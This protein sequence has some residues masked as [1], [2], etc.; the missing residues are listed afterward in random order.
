MCHKRE[1]MPSREVVQK[2]IADYQDL[3]IR[4]SDATEDALR[5]RHAYKV[6]NKMSDKI[7]K[8]FNRFR[9]DDTLVEEVL[10]RSL[11][12]EDIR[13]R[14]WAAVH[15]LTLKKHIN[16][17]LEVLKEASNKNDMKMLSFDAKQTIEIWERQGHL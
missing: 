17:S 13:V 11:H 16:E 7:W 14:T 1:K 15:L 10:T 9:A 8:L 4:Q 5:N 3:A 6:I 2:L 12:S